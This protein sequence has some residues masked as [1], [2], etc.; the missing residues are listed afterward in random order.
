MSYVYDRGHKGRRKQGF[1]ERREP[2]H[3]LPAKEV[4]QI[5]HDRRVMRRLVGKLRFTDDGMDLGS[6]RGVMA[7][8]RIERGEAGGDPWAA[9]SWLQDQWMVGCAR[10][11]LTNYDHLLAKTHAGI[12]SVTV[13]EECFKQLKFK[14]IDMVEDRWP[15]LSAAC[16]RQR[17]WAPREQLMFIRKRNA[18]LQER[19]RGH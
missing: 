10:H 7:A 3:P 11:S 19:D 17:E 5:R 18:Q 13:R 1:R 12:R 2:E 16:E 15:E 8:Q 14:A 4:R 6:L 9:P